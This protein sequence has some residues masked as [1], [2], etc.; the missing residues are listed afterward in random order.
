MR[1]LA[2][3]DIQGNWQA[4]ADAY[5]RELRLGRPPDAIVHTGNLGLWSTALVVDSNDVSYAR[6]VVAFSSVL[7]PSVVESVNNLSQ[8]SGGTTSSGTG[9][10][11]DEIEAM[12]SA[13]DGHRLSHYDD[14]IGGTHKQLPCPVYSVYGPLDHPSVVTQLL[15]GQ[16]NVPNLFI[17]DHNHVYVLDDEVSGSSVKLY[18]L[19]GTVK[20]HSLFDHGPIAKDD[21]DDHNADVVAPVC[22]KVGELWVT[23]V[24]IAELY[25]KAM[26]ATTTT[27]GCAS[28]DDTTNSADNDGA[29]SS[30]INIFMAHAPVIKTPLLE[31]LAIITHADFTISQGLH[32]RYPV[33]GNG[34][35]FV[36]SMGGSAGYLD[37]YRSKFSRLRMILGE[38][39][40]IVRHDVCRHLDT[41]ILPIIELALSLFDKIPVSIADTVDE[42][43]PLRVAPPSADTS[44]TTNNDESSAKPVLKRINDYYFQAYY[45][46]WHFNVCDVVSEDRTH[47]NVMG[48]L[49]DE[50]HNF[51][52]EHCTSQ[53]FNFRFKKEKQPP[54]NEANSTGA[55]SIRGR[56]TTR[57]RGRRPGRR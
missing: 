24:Q 18:G 28:E 52:L 37:H 29:V 55:S 17:V 1:L 50:N 31:H 46:L 43:V 20:L 11:N 54:N 9:E 22:G 16:L 7:S 23:M 47:L 19:G 39:W 48:F 44:T 56:G 38:L 51:V 13:L 4:F 53:G 42:I 40:A 25:V 5:A 36:D 6:Q 2:V 15:N 33:S 12:A 8:I 27:D 35:S 34:M 3:S 49:L 32:F 41:S 45:N 10:N 21:N 26:E 57:H 30:T 14:Y